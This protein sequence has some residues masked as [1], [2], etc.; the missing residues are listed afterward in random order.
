MPQPKHLLNVHQ[1]LINEYINFLTLRTFELCGKIRRREAQFQI[2]APDPY[3]PN[4][5]RTDLGTQVF[6]S[7]I[8]AVTHIVRPLF[9]TPIDEGPR[10]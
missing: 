1:A 10:K 6:L 8:S 9:L 7:S 2:K 4:K 3:P 5:Q